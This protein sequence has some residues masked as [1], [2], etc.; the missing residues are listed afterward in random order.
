MATDLI[1]CRF[2][3]NDSA[4]TPFPATDTQLFLRVCLPLVF[5]A[6]LKLFQP[7]ATSANFGAATSNKSALMR[8]A[9]GTIHSRKNGI[10]VLL[11]TC[12]SATTL[13]PHC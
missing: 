3:W 4:A 5:A 9:A 11:G 12:A 13:R 8:F 1:F 10:A 6:V 2:C 7:L